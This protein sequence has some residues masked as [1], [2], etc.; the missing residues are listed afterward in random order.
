[1]PEDEP[2]APS[3][4]EEPAALTDADIDR[5]PE[6]PVL[7]RLIRTLVLLGIAAFGVFAI[8]LA[9]RPYR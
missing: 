5:P 6:A 2:V 1:L 7:P 8:T 3:A 4:E 9:R